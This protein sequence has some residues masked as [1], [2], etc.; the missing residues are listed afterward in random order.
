MRPGNFTFLLLMLC[1]EWNLRKQAD[2]LE[3]KVKARTQA[4][5]RMKEPGGGWGRL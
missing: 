5:K 4:T 3:K 1:E 2:A